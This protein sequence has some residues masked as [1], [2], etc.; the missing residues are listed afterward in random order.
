MRIGHP[1]S[2]SY[3]SLK[4]GAISQLFLAG[5]HTGGGDYSHFESFPLI[6]LL[7]IGSLKHLILQ[8]SWFAT[9]SQ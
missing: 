3:F 1:T 5:F 8:I 4:L 7:G 9:E 2:K 6:L